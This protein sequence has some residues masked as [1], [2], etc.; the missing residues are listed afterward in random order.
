MFNGAV[1]GFLQLL[2]NLGGKAARQEFSFTKLKSFLNT[3]GRVTLFD[4]LSV[5]RFFKL[6][7]KSEQISTY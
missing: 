6:M 4:I 7:R 1:F 3:K 2:G 5:L